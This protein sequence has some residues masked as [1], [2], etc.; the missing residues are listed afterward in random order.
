M[1][2]RCSCPT[3]TSGDRL[4][5]GRFSRDRHARSPSGFPPRSRRDR[6]YRGRN[7]TVEYRWADGLYD[8][9]PALAAEFVNRRVDVIV[10]AGGSI[11]GRV[12]KAATSTIPIIALAWD[13]PV[14]L[15]FAARLNRQRTGVVQLVIASGAKVIAFLNNPAR[16]NASRPRPCRVVL[17]G[18]IALSRFFRRR[19]ASASSAVLRCVARMSGIFTPV[20]DRR[21]STMVWSSGIERPDRGPAV[22]ALTRPCD[23][24]R[25]TTFVPTETLL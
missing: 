24:R 1:V 13:D 14:W 20:S 10:A 15:G 21:S 23:Q 16:P 2:A 11:A 19:A 18:S 25:T 17:K 6:L 8:R 9:L 4:P 7:V 22:Q 12:A 5:W 3:E